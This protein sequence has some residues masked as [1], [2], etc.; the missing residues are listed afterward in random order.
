MQAAVVVAIL[1]LV[2]LE[3]AGQWAEVRVRLAEVRPRWGRILLSGLIVAASFA[4]LIET[5]RRMLTAWS[6]RLSFLE[7]SRIW[8]ISGL[9][10]YLP[11][12]LWQ[13][14]AMAAMARD[15]GVSPVASVGSALV[16]NIVNIITGAVVVLGAGSRVLDALHPRSRLAAVAL[17]A[18]LG[19]GLVVLPFVLPALVRL[20]ARLTRRELVAP[21]LPPRTIW[22]GIAGTTAAWL[23]YGLAFEQLVAGILGRADEPSA[24]YISVYTSSYL[25]G[26]LFLPAPAGVG[27]R[28]WAMK[29]GF[30]ALGLGGTADAWVIAVVSRLWLTVLEVIPGLLFIARDAIAPRAPRP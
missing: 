21:E 4:V 3:I 22:I 23:L 9:G 30:A 25:V 19:G 5:W 6:A 11:G 7:A 12:K 26:Y 15:R 13:I 2:A 29:S 24:A 20:A 18:V 14:G 1:V 17:I 27:V 10:R 8:A 28:E 16:I